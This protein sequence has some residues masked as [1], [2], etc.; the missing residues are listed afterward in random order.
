MDLN[1]APLLR[2][3]GVCKRFARRAGA[4]ADPPRTGAVLSGF[5]LD[6]APG[7]ITALVGASGAGK[8][9][10]ALCLL[11][12][13]PLD[14]GTIHF[15]GLDLTHLSERALRPLRP[16]LQPVFQ[17]PWGSLTP[18]LTVAA[19][20][21]EPLRVHRRYAASELRART[22]AA[23]DEVGLPQTLLPARPGALSGGQRQRV[24]L[25]RALILEPRLLV[26]DEP[27]SAL[28]LSEQAR[29]LTLLDRLRATRGLACLFV[30]HD[31]GV[32]RHLA[33]GVAV[34]DGGRIVEEGPTPEVPLAPDRHIRHTW[35]RIATLDS[36][37]R[38]GYPR[39]PSG[40]DPRRVS[41]ADT[42]SE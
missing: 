22:A 32:V 26:C 42:L 35:P 9:T 31:L 37:I 29:I 20:L 5:D 19:L 30:S 36:G 23:L 14:A 39:R 13:L 17:D 1:I 12:L 33:D 8:T 24:A 2:A 25:A 4:G 21:S 41:V 11:R 6:L 10:A 18:H 28:D 16:N 38:I 15:D 34:L 27:T 40:D 3:R 7:R